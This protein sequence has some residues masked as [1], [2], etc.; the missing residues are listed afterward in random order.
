MSESRFEQWYSRS[1]GNVPG[2]DDAENRDIIKTIWNGAVEHIAE[3]FT[4][5]LFIEYSGNQVADII[6]S[7]KEPKENH[8]TDYL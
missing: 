8:G 1:F 3:Q 6:R 2:A 5:D 7:M 4:H